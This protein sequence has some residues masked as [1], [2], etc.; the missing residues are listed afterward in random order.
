MNKTKKL[1]AFLIV[2]SLMFVYISIP[3]FAEESDTETFDITYTETEGLSISFSQDGQET[4]DGSLCTY[5]FTKGTSVTVE[6]KALSGYVLKSIKANG[7]NL[8]V[9]AE[10]SEFEYPFTEDVVLV[11]T[12]EEK[13][14]EKAAITV[15]TGENFTYVLEG[16]DNQNKAEIGSTVTLEITPAKGYIVSKLL[17]NNN[18][19]EPTTS[20]SFKVKS[21]NVFTITV[22]EEAVVT[23]KTLTVIVEGSGNVT[24]VTGT[25]YN[26]GT[27]VELGLTPNTGYML[28]SLKIGDESVS[29]SQVQNN[30]FTFTINDDITVSAVFVKTVTITATIGKGGSVT[31]NGRNISGSVPIK[32]AEGSNVEI[33]VSPALGYT[34]DTVKVDNTQVT[35]N[36][37]NSYTM[38]SINSS[39]KLSVTFKPVESGVKQYTISAS[40]ATGGIITPGTSVVEEGK[41]I[42]FTI[43][44]D[45]GKE[46]D[47]VKVDGET[48]SLINYTY[49]FNNVAA[50]HNIYVTFK[51]SDGGETG[52]A[53]GINDV[54]WDSTETIY[55]NL[56]GNSVVS[57]EV[58]SKITDDCKDK[59]VVFVSQNY[60]WTL[61]KGASI[62]I[63]SESADLGVELNG[64]LLSEVSSIIAQSAENAQFV[65][66]TYDKTFLF[67]QG[68]KLEVKL[69]SNFA[70]EDVQQFI[71]SRNSK[72]LN[73]PKNI[74]GEE[75]YDIRSVSADGWVEVDYNNDKDIVF[76]E[77]L[78][79]YYTITT[80]ATEGGTITPMGNKKVKAADDIS[81][82]II[83]NDD[84]V[85]DTLLIDGEEESDAA[86]QTTYEKQF[87]A[88]SED[89]TISVTFATVDDYEKS[90][91][92]GSKSALIVALIIISLAAAGAAALFIIKWRQNKY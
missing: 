41:S 28:A 57:A 7:V 30:R 75:E 29:I 40:A 20:Y 32:T 80:S 14:I 91:A 52:N 66:A 1:L 22:E 44:P 33:I 8:P 88:V 27:K 38:S 85:I 45:N 24:P 56:T 81:F 42:T 87:T 61:P 58:F 72:E 35:L 12:L 86:G 53:I 64:S 89:H 37:Q 84:Y 60:K 17:Y 55:I 13:I 10:T 18:E 26:P 74:S 47:T 79:S 63:N 76:C 83:A 67:P 51:D 68:T 71:Y 48:V 69:G 15:N 36:E 70:A 82:S 25:K 59:T 31:V 77:V 9:L 78:D 2:L 73:N 6:F 46:V 5:T 49:T 4:V 23:Q 65:L 16:A 19:L 90:K 34:V 39:K 21:S 62:E 43:T 54:N 11:V 3:A 50:P 92:S